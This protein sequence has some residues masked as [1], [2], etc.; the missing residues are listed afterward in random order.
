MVL[1]HHPGERVVKPELRH[2]L[3]IR[4][5]QHLRH[6]HELNQEQIE[7]QAGENQPDACQRKA[8]DGDAGEPSHGAESGGGDSGEDHGDVNE[9]ATEIGAHRDYAKGHMCNRHDPE[10]EGF[11]ERGVPGG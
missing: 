11:I 4:D 7:Q 9:P 3:Q 2:G 8:V 10:L 1:R 5:Q 6:Q